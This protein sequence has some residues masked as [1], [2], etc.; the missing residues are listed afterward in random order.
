MTVHRVEAELIDVTCN[1]DPVTVHVL[2]P[3]KATASGAGLEHTWT[4]F[5]GQDVPQIGDQIEV[6]VFDR[7]DNQPNMREL[8]DGQA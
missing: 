5:P 6:S 1:H 7:V 8:Q 4:V 3:V 2:G